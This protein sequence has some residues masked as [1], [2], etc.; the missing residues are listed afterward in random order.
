MTL[1]N[2]I[3]RHGREC[4]QGNHGCDANALCNKIRQ[5]LKLFLQPR[6][7]R[8]RLQLYW[9]DTLRMKVGVTCGGSPHLACKRDRIKM[10]DYVERRVTPPKRDT[11]PTWGPPPPCKQALSLAGEKI[12]SHSLHTTNQLY[13]STNSSYAIFL[14]IE[15]LLFVMRPHIRFLPSLNKETTSV[16][17][18]HNHRSRH[19]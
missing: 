13:S 11:T 8:R 6:I 12:L 14:W 5:I 1:Q 9:N 19:Y 2:L 4:A 15:I 10:R 17:I 18:N 7:R 16:H 3:F